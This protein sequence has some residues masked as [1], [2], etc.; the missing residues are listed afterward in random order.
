MKRKEYIISFGILPRIVNDEE[1]E[2]VKNFFELLTEHFEE[3][4]YT[5]PPDGMPGRVKSYE[6]KLLELMEN[7]RIQKIDRQE[8]NYLFIEEDKENSL[9]AILG[10]DQR[11][12]DFA[13]LRLNYLEHTF[14]R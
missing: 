6:E 8:R 3:V 10:D 11:F 13:K 1:F 9:E 2:I 14:I 7:L 5:L 12:R 4:Y